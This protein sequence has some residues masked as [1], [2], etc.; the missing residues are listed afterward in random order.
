[1]SAQA[2]EVDIPGHAMTGPLLY[3]S[4]KHNTLVPWLSSA[5]AKLQ[6]LLTV[7]LPELRRCLE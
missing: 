2:R 4:A 7:M 3:R 1:M 6:E 5:A